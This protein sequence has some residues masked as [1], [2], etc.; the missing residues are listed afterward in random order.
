MVLMVLIVSERVLNALARK[1]Q[2][3]SLFVTNLKLC[4]IVD[5]II[6]T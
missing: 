3:T 6:Y 5:Q 2:N 4:Q 1:V